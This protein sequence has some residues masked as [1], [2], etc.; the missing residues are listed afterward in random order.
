[1]PARFKYVVKIGGKRAR[2]ARKVTERKLSNKQLLETNKLH[3]YVKAGRVRKVT[4][5]KMGSR[6]LLE[7]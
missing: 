5:R 3:I 7:A 1:L 4:E 6:H 2:R